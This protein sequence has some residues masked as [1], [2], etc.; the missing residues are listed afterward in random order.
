MNYGADLG[1]KIEELTTP[2][3]V[4]D[5]DELDHNFNVIADTYKDTECKMRQHAK[6]IKCPEILHHQINAGG[7]NG[8]V[9]A[10]KVS[11]A[12]LMVEGGIDDILIT[13]Q[14]VGDKK[15]KRLAYLAKRGNIK[16]CVDNVEN[17][18]D[19]STACVEAKSKI[20]ILI[21]VN[22]NMNRAGVRNSDQGAEL[23]K[24]ADSLPGIEFMGVMSHQTISGAPNIRQ[25]FK[26]GKAAIGICLDV[27]HK[28]EDFGIDVPIV[29]S[30]ETYTYDVAP[31]L[32]EVTEV[33]GGTYAFMGTTTRY[34]EE[35]KVAAKIVTTIT[36]VKDDVYFIDAGYKALG[37]PLGIVPQVEGYEDSLTFQSIHDYH[38]ILKR[39]SNMEFEVGSTLNLHSS[40]TDILVNRWDK[41]TCIRN[42]VVEKIIDITARGCHN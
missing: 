39:G 6:N 16:V 22:T 9:C 13:S 25:R 24:L 36:D 17:I 18:K 8:G 27:K 40:Q 32:G 35:F 38:S 21:E 30:G 20:G 23:A 31:S 41:F 5:M 33:E 26:E 1:R 19:I 42:G 12:E 37:G 15:V 28:I 14:I 29:S 10:A 2:R 34:M 4:I 11:E 3:L 7:T